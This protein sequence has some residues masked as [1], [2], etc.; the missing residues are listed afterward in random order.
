ML[1]V[2]Y[3]G[4]KPSDITQRFGA[5]QIQGGIH[6]GVDF[7]P[8]GAYGK[9]LLAPELCEVEKIITDDTLDNDYYPKL[10]KGY[11]IMLRSLINNNRQY[12]LWHCCQV[13]PVKVGQTLKQGDA[14]AQMG[15]SGMCYSGG[16]YVPLKD[17]NSGKGSHLH[18]EL[19]VNGS[20]ADILPLIDF[21]L[22]VHLDTIKAVQ[23]TLA[24]MMNL[25]L[26]RK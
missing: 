9:F 13:F 23:Q 25:I 10:Q 4:A 11:G 22:P 15:N 1:C 20:Y 24:G 3:I 12:L 2:P 18:Y 19:R 7:C 16:V 26:N 14:I 21:T 8:K 17:R 5:K 6:T